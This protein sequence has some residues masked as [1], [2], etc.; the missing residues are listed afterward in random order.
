[1]RFRLLF[2]QCTYIINLTVRIDS[3]ILKPEESITHKH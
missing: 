2:S 3:C 1:M